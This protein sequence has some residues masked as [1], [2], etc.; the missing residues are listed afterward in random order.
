LSHTRT[1]LLAVIVLESRIIHPLFMAV[2]AQAHPQDP[3]KF[4]CVKGNAGQHGRRVAGAC[5]G[6][7]TQ[8]SSPH[9]AALKGSPI[10]DLRLAKCQGPVLAKR[11]SPRQVL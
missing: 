11:A 3:L 7:P 2:Q 8:A 10:P 4:W 5:P 9:G 6:Y 1:A